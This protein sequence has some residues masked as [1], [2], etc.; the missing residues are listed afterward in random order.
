MQI[1][2]ESALTTPICDE[3]QTFIT[4]F[5]HPRVNIMILVW[6]PAHALDVIIRHILVAFAFAAGC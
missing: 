6:M 2:L 4:H 1:I 3:A 5:T